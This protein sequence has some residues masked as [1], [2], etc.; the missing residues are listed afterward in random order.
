VSTVLR[1]QQTACR[2]C[3]H[4]FN[5]TLAFDKHRVG[6]QVPITQPMQRRCLTPDEMIAKGMSVNARGFWITE[7]R[8]FARVP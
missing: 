2:T 5:S 6:P 1:G 3:G 7:A 8:T 4:L